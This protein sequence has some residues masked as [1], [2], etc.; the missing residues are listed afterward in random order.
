[1]DDF[2]IFPFVGSIKILVLRA[3]ERWGGPKALLWALT[4]FFYL[5]IARRLP[6]YPAFRRMRSI[7]PASFWRGLTPWRHYFLMIRNWQA[8]Q[9]TVLLADRLRSS[10]WTE[11]IRIKGT[12]PH[13]LP[14]WGKRPVI[15]VFL[16]TGGYPLLRYWLRAQGLPSAT[17]AVNPISFSQRSL[18]KKIIAAADEINGLSGVPH[19]FRVKRPI[20]PMLNF[21][22]PGHIL[23]L[24]LDALPSSSS[25]RF[26]AN[27]QEIHLRTGI[28]KMA[29]ISQAVLLPV[30]I[31]PQGLC[32]FEIR[33]GIPVPDESIDR[34]HPEPAVQFML[35]QLWKDVEEDPSLVNWCTLHA[36]APHSIPHHLAWP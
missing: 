17:Y 29:A 1:M 32:R 30:S 36:L 34:L 27:G 26:H 16:H 7:L 21:L 18:A 28:V 13:H 10:V 25:T 9:A 15:L 14:E 11:R 22:V 3:S 12:P 5:S 2:V 33:F 31:V 20:R 35:D 19:I 23:N 8:T 4:P 6:D 24:A